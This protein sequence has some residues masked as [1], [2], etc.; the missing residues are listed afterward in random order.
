MFLFPLHV[1]LG[2]SVL[3]VGLSW[4]ASVMVP[5]HGHALAG[6][7]IMYQAGWP[8]FAVLA[9][10]VPPGPRSVS[11]PG[12][13]PGLASCS[14]PQARHWHPRP[15]ADC[16]C[17]VAMVP[18]AAGQGRGWGLACGAAGFTGTHPESLPQLNGHG[19]YHDTDR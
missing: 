18:R 12:L 3:A 4:P 5:G 2:S 16:R 11:G 14:W 1:C 8:A 19:P 15:A 10:L 6:V 7:F 17:A 9:V 13:G